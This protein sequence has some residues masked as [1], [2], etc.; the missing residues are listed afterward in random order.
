[1]GEG[2]KKARKE[3]KRGEERKSLLQAWLPQKHQCEKAQGS[4]CPKSSLVGSGGDM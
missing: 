3:G 2:N 1:M 4:K